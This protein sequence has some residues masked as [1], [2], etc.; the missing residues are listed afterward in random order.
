MERYRY[1]DELEFIHHTILTLPKRVQEVLKSTHFVT[2][3]CHKFLGIPC[4]EPAD[5]RSFNEISFVIPFENRPH[6]FL[7]RNHVF[8]KMILLHELGHA[9]R[10]FLDNDC[11]DWIDP[12]ND[13]A[14]TNYHECY[15]T[16]FQSFF[17]REPLDECY[18]H[19]WEDLIKHDISTYRYFEKQFGVSPHK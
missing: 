7:L 18:F 1:R 9:V 10:M 13:Y 15:A 3:Y 19:N 17:T 6:I 2:G 4:G 8:D 12:L 11:P 14:S 16:A 5:G